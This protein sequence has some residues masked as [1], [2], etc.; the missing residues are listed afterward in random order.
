MFD[1]TNDAE[2]FKTP[3]EL[4]KARF[5]RDGALWKKRKETFV[6]LYEAKMVQMYDHRAASVVVNNENW[7]RQGQT[8]AT[9][10]VQHQ[11]QEYTVEP[12]WWVSESAVLKAIGPEW[13]RGFLAF[14]DITSPTNQR[15]M[16]ATA[17]PWTA[18]TNHLPL[19]L[20]SAQAE[21]DACLLANLNS[22][23]LD[24]TGQTEIGG[25]TLNFFIVEQ[26]PIFGPISTSNSSRGISVERLESWIAGRVLKLTCTSNDIRSRSQ[27]PQASNLSCINGIPRSEPS[28]WPNL[29]PLSSSST[30]WNAKTSSTS[31]RPSAES[32]KMEKASNR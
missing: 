32:T 13:K 9:S 12:R 15:T 7:M 10:L 16:I 29:T 25:V 21:R 4:Q 14:K 8:E 19:I 26:L 3:D 6:P 28:C 30:A 22:V 31:S 2:L 17:M 11:N 20:T 24:Y 18:V 5:K 1:Q 23:V 27:S